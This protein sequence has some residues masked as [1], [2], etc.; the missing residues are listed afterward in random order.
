MYAVYYRISR[1]GPQR[2]RGA[3]SNDN[4]RL[5]KTIHSSRIPRLGINLDRG[6][7]RPDLLCGT[8]MGEEDNAG[9]YQYLFVDWRYQC[10]LYPGF[11]S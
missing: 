4:R 1:L 3:I 6:I 8:E 9:L 11:R 10:E 2:T 7:C 5:Q